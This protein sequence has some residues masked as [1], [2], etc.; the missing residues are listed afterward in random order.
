[1]RRV[2]L[3]YMGDSVE[4]PLGET[5]IGRDIACAMRF[6][7]PSVS[8]RHLRFIH[9]YGEVF[10]EDLGSSNGTLLNGNPID[11]A[12][13]LLH[14]DTLSV[15]TR[16]LTVHV[17]EPS[18]LEQPATFVLSKLPPPKGARGSSQI[19]ATIPPPMGAEDAMPA[20]PPLTRRRHDRLPVE[21][22]VVYASG[23]L[24]V[25]AVSRD[26]SESGV[27][28]CSSVLDPIGTG[29]TLTILADGGPA[30]VMRGVVRRVVER[31][32]R[33]DE[34]IGFGVEFVGIDAQQL[35]WLRMLVA[36]TTDPTRPFD[37]T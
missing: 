5:L 35:A 15:G 12:Q 27:F 2:F 33:R 28:V 7:D 11:G 29:C 13:R 1:V 17:V 30:M 31:P 24:E 20:V 36:R 14:R 18:E 25:E 10:V 8:R 32:E 26:L 21:L 37:L 19:A 23:E 3:E 9:R 34:R 16:L 4:L 6:N 22:R